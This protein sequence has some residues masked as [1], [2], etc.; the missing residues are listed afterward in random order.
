MDT[1]WIS[2]SAGLISLATLILSGIS[3]RQK[4]T[5][6]YV[7]SIEKRLEAAETALARCRESEHRQEEEVRELSRALKACER[8]NTEL[9]EMIIEQRK[10]KDDD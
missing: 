5:A 2:L 10:D 8:R 1:F 9:M 6:N 7:S 4:N 3:L